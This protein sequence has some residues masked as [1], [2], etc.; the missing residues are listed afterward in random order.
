MY[1]YGDD[2][3]QTPGFAEISKADRL[4]G[5]GNPSIG[6]PTGP[7]TTGAMQAP[8]RVL[9]NP[10]PNP[11]YGGEMQWAANPPLEAGLGLGLSGAWQ[12]NFE[13]PVAV[14]RQD[15]PALDDGVGD[16]CVGDGCVAPGL[17]SSQFNALRNQII[18]G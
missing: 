15:V 13:A 1:M 17:L 10:N 8:L 14:G 16:G 7:R 18:R 4:F 9:P 2:Q 11:A 3:P 5:I 6:F 12:P